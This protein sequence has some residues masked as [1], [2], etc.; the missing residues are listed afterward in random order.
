MRVLC[1]LLT[2]SLALLGRPLFQQAGL[3]LN[4]LDKV[5]QDESH[6]LVGP[7]IRGTGD[8]PIS[9]YCRDAIV[10]ARYVYTTYLLTGKDTNLNGAYLSLETTARR[11]CG[12]AE[13]T[14][15]AATA[16][17]W[18][19]K[20]PEVKRTYP[21]DSE[22]ER[23]KPDSRGFRTV[24]YKVQLTFRDSRGHV[25]KVEAFRATE[26]ELVKK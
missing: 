22:V 18:Q 15:R 13:G 17:D 25:T 26:R 5:Y 7:E 19:W 2:F 24:P 9:C 14:L 16:T 6:C 10:D 12:G 11:M 3:P 20:G 23:I 4:E 21:S 8:Q 1:G